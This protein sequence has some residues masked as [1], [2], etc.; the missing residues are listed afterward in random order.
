[1]TLREIFYIFFSYK[2]IGQRL[3]YESLNN[4]KGIQC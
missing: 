3:S 1:M 2:G 4:L